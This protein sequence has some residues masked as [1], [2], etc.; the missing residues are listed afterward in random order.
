MVMP[1]PA[2][3]FSLPKLPAS[4]AHLVTAL[5]FFLDFK[6]SNYAA[7]TPQVFLGVRSWPVAPAVSSD[8]WPAGSRSAWL[9]VSSPRGSSMK[10]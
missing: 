9:Q 1:L 4:M 10:Q 8:T 3:V 2:L 5:S 7:E 6:A